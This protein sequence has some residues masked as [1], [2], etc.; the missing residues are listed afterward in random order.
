MTATEFGNRRSNACAAPIARFVRADRAQSRAMDDS[1][2]LIDLPTLARA[3]GVARIWIKDE[4]RRLLGNFKSLGGIPA[5]LAELDRVGHAGTTLICASDGNHGLAVAEAA[6]SRSARARIYLPATVDGARVA[7]IARTG[8]TICRVDGSYDAAV[9]M[10]RR[11]ARDGEGFLVPDTSEDPHDAVVATVLAGYARLPSEIV[12]QLGS[13]WPTHIFV[14]AG[15]GGLAAAVAKGLLSAR[16]AELIIVEPQSAACVG[17]ALAAGHP[18][19]VEGTLES[20]ADMLSCGLAS[21]SAIETL[22]DLGCRAVSVDEAKL[23]L[24][25]DLLAKHGGPRTTPSGAAGLA[26]M[27]KALSADGPNRYGL[28]ARSA[29]LLLVT[30]GHLPAA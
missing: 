27:V 19:Q 3:L 7:R 14:Q 6:R 26:G 17:A 16:R 25:P 18:V 2:P 21:A 28:N 11:A 13:D 4:S 23:K 22:L 5:A 20:C 1:T 30:E 24:A 29:V 12:D 15:V 8:A 9:L 10:A